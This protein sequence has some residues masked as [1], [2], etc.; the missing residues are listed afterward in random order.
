MIAQ[1]KICFFLEGSWNISDVWDKYI[2]LE[3]TH[4][5]SFKSSWRLSQAARPFWLS[6]FLTGVLDRLDRWRHNRTR[7]GRLGT[8]HVASDNFWG[9]LTQRHIKSSVTQWPQVFYLTAYV[10]L[11]GLSALIM[12]SFCSELLFFHSWGNFSFSGHSLSTNFFHLLA[13][14]SMSRS[15]LRNSSM[16]LRAYKGQHETSQSELPWGEKKIHGARESEF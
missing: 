11:S 2:P 5:D 1:R 4:V 10:I 7:W 8:K 16:L 15:K 14:P 9:S 12:H 3:Q 6:R 13:D